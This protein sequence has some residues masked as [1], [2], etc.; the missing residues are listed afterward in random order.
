M[1]IAPLPPGIARERGR[2]GY[3]VEVRVRPYP[4]RK[5]RYPDGTPVAVMLAWRDTTLA[6]LKA[7]KAQLDAAARATADPL[8]PRRSVAEAVRTFRDDVHV[9]LTTKMDPKLHEHTQYQWRRY[10]TKA[11]AEPEIGRLPRQ[12]ITGPMW[13]A[14]LAKW[15]RH[16]IPVGPDDGAIKNPATGE[17]RRV[18]PPGPLSIDTVHKI[19]TCWIGFYDAMDAGSGLPNPARLVP[20]RDTSSVVVEA[21]GIPMPDA[22]AIIDKLPRGTHTWARLTLMATLGL[23]PVEVMRIKDAKDWHRES[24]TLYIRTAKRGRPRTLPLGDRAVEALEMLDRESGRGGRRRAKGWGHFTA[25]P[26]ARMFHAAVTAAG[27][28]KYE[29]IR[30]YDLRHSFGTEAYRLTGDLKATAEALGQKTLKMAERYVEAAVSSAVGNL[31]GKVTARMPK[32]KKAASEKQQRGGLRVV[33][34][35]S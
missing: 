7:A 16:G 5:Q 35:R 21:R 17:R 8:A 33:G 10:L 9:Y 29:P 30:P 26:A 20:R 22:L 18:V 34:G 12:L 1:S 6:E 32:P 19:R 14:L 3:V 13:S 2:T 24:R 11:A 4:K 31:F 27:L 28:E 15:E 23:R 25:A